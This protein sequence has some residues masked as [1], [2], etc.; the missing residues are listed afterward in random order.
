MEYN[1]DNIYYKLA[2]EYFSKK[3][4]VKSYPVSIYTLSDVD[5][6][7]DCI[8]RFD[9]ETIQKFEMLRDK[10]KEECKDIIPGEY[11]DECLSPEEYEKIFGEGEVDT[12]DLDNPVYEYN[13]AICVLKDNNL[14]RH[15]CCYA[16]L[17]DESYIRILALCLQDKHMNLNKLRYADRDLYDTITYMLDV[18]YFKAPEPTSPWYAGKYPYIV[19]LDEAH[20]DAEQIANAH[21]EIERYEFMIYPM[22]T[23]F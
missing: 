14:E 15:A 13:F 1:E 22:T 6:I 10:Y 4:R 8:M 11:L 9:D 21:P 20:N 5:G 19:L 12:I 23:T 7:K 18:N 16:C 17:A 2:K 3:D